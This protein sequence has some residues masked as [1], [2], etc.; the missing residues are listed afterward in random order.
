[1]HV[2]LN[3]AVSDPALGREVEQIIYRDPFLPPSF[4]DSVSF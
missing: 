1:M 4:S 3:C 2:A